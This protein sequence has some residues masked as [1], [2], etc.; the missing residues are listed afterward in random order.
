MLS[1]G[2]GA[3][4]NS[5]TA[6]VAAGSGVVNA[7]TDLAEFRRFQDAKREGSASI[8]APVLSDSGSDGLGSRVCVCVCVFKGVG[9]GPLIPPEC[10]R[11]RRRRR[12]RLRRRR[13]RRRRDEHGSPPPSVRPPTFYM[14]K[15]MKKWGPAAELPAGGRGGARLGEALTRRASAGTG[16]RRCRLRRPSRPHGPDDLRR[17]SPPPGCYNTRSNNNFVLLNLVM[18]VGY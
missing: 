1:R 9:G 10:P 16:R 5:A 11:R 6:A 4:L 14:E 12:R 13:R 8:A 7:S 15:P 17:A 2:A 18:I 3:P